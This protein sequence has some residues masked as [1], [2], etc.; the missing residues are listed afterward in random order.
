MDKEAEIGFNY[1]IL[2]TTDGVC[3]A[4]L[5]PFN[6][7]SGDWGFKRE[8]EN[9]V[10]PLEQK[11]KL[12]EITLKILEMELRMCP[13]LTPEIKFQIYLNRRACVTFVEM[14]QYVGLYTSDL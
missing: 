12:E 9:P 2:A 13:D 11:M 10:R 6:Y 5:Y 4:G 8:G 3:H 1:G 7:E 14:L